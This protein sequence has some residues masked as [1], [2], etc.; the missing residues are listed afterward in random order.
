VCVHAHT[1]T[2]NTQ[3]EPRG[4]DAL[5]EPIKSSTTVFHD[6]CY[7]AQLCL[8]LKWREEGDNKMKNMTYYLKAFGVI[9]LSIL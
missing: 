2:L 5:E 8:E 1:Y 4:D 6:L 9:F 7:K 3:S